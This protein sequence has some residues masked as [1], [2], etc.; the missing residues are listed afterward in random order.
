M[1]KTLNFYFL[2]FLAICLPSAFLFA[3]PVSSPDLK[4]LAV[5]SN[6]DV[7]LTWTVP[8][9]PGGN[10]V[11]YKIYSSLIQAGP[12]SL[13]TTISTY[14]QTNYTHVG[15][16]ANSNRVYYLIRTDYNPGP[17]LS[18]PL[19]TFSTI[20]LLVTNPG[21]GVANLSW[22]KISLQN[23][24]T[25][26]GKYKIYREYPAGIWTLRDSTQ[27]LSYVDEIDICSAVLNYRVEI[28]DNTG[29]TSVS[30]LAGGTVF[31]DLTPPA[32]APIDTV[33]VNGSS[34]ATISWTPSPSADAD[35]IV[36]Y[37]LQGGTWQPIATIPVPAT[38][39]VYSL[40]NAG[41]VSEFYRTA[42]KDS[43]GNISPLGT[44]HKTIYLSSSVDICAA[45]AS[46][47]WN[48][49]VNWIPPVNQYEIWKS[50]NAG[51][52]SLIGTNINSDTTYTDTG[53]VLGTQYC[54]FVRATSGAKSSSSNRVCFNP[55]VTQPPAFI[56]NRFA[57]VLSNTSILVKAH[58]DVSATSVK[59][60]RIQRAIGPGGSF[61]VIVPAILPAG[62][63]ITYTDNAVNTTTNS[64]LYKIEAMDSCAHVIMTSNRDTTMLLTAT[65]APNLDINLA[66]NDY[67]NWDGNVDYYEIY[68]AVD[69]VW[70]GGPIATVVYSGSGGTYTDDIAPFLS[71]KG[72]FAYYVVAVE[73]T[74]NSYGFKD[75]SASN[76]VSVDQ[77]PKFYV[78][79]AFTPNGDN[80]NDT[81]LPV[82]G[83][84]EQTNY[85]L[86]IFDKTGTPIFESISPA[87]GWD[88][89]KKG[90][91]CQAGVYMYLIRC[92]AANGDDSK[93]SGTISLFR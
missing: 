12:Y 82:I 48:K 71:S 36:I 89:K 84:I 7:T 20:N 53:L 5:A 17:I 47:T 43:C 56:Y 41:T 46:L 30:N 25:S 57:T 91:P 27:S 3:Q 61:S 40:S 80:T 21:T 66:W 18:S 70:G 68:R 69:G 52:F 79:N 6:G 33:S 28:S 34:Q 9:V 37:Q 85:S 42:V 38:S 88:G 62:S 39:Y 81:F 14:S 77:Y 54:Y 8:A 92:R 11:D 2:F 35:S 26:S 63:T 75:S 44:F 65:L 87:I 32:L 86:M 22:N 31:M 74:G 24:S 15:A 10:F 58:I 49:Y 76:I 78:P 67:G 93:I 16:N 90:H 19:D 13:V 83:F 51:P 29:C 73:A 72:N 23:I 50:T 1:R 4:C 45:T 55:S 60:Y 64:Y 59:Y